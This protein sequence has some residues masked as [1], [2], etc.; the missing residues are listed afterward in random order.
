MMA[1][2]TFGALLPALIIQIAVPF[3]A[4][5]GQWIVP[6]KHIT[7]AAGLEES[8]ATLF[9][10]SDRDAN[11]VINPLHRRGVEHVLETGIE[12]AIAGTG[13]NEDNQAFVV[14]LLAAS[15][16]GL[17]IAREVGRR[18]VSFAAA[19][20]TV[21]ADDVRGV[22]SATGG[23]NDDAALR[24]ALSDLVAANLKRNPESVVLLDAPVFQTIP[25]AMSAFHTCWDSHG[26][27]TG[28]TLGAV[29]CHRSTFV[30]VV[31]MG[32]ADLGGVDGSGDCNPAGH[33]PM[34]DGKLDAAKAWLKAHVL[35]ASRNA[36]E[37][38]REA[39]LRRVS[40]TVLFV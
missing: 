36:A 16:D 28:P 6:P 18:C 4:R 5:G 40:D 12:A 27:L 35:P 38:E 32:T 39:I 21:T 7:S 23:T 25:G 34:Y 19:G 24:V 11:A 30:V 26:K 3:T 33:C 10:T 20:R 8:F 2:R 17:A 22:M 9:E 14:V 13:R 1:L 15:A 29:P 37:V 31:D